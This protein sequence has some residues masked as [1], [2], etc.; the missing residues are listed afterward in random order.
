M[1]RQPKI[2][3]RAHLPYQQRTS[4]Q[5]IP[6]LRLRDALQKALKRR[7]LTCDMCEVTVFGNDM[8]I[9]WDTDI[10]LIRAEEVY[11]KV[12][13]KVRIMT[14]ISHQVGHYWHIIRCSL[15]IIF[16]NVC[17]SSSLE[18]HFFRWPSVNAVV[19]FYL[20]VCIVTSAIFGFINGVVTK[21][22]CYA[23]K[24]IWIVTTNSC[25]LIIQK[26]RLAY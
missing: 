22:H 11:V 18:K 12:L 10:S 4:V 17:R 16:V 19:D 7:N 23:I 21:F 2:F 20:L 24:L 1:T 3:L 8:P 14:H 15:S 6:G 5:V 9:S 13:E 26:V 25:W